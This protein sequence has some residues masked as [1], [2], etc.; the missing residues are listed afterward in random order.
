MF[1][2]GGGVGK[3]ADPRKNE[4]LAAICVKPIF[5]GSLISNQSAR[6]VAS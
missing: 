2:G 3:D 5:G 4:R 6:P 1:F